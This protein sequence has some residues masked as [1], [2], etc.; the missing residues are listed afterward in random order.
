MACSVC[1]AGHAEVAM[2][3]CGHIC[4]CGLCRKVLCWEHKGPT[5]NPC[6]VCSQPVQT[7]LKVFFDGVPVE[8]PR[9][10]QPVAA[11]VK[12]MQ[13]AKPSPHGLILA[14]T[15]GKSVE[16]VKLD[17]VELIEAWADK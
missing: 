6:P 3:P 2:V 17:E 14:L 5:S 15:D 1:L 10:P 11:S 8:A 7:T 16:Q 12:E 4:I 13:L 9:P